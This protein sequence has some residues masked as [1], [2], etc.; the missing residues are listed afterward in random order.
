M[1]SMNIRRFWETLL[2][3]VFAALPLMLTIYIVIWLARTAEIFFGGVL[4]VFIPDRWYIPGSG[5]L[6]GLL[7]IF[8]LGLLTRV[9][10]FR[11]IA[12]YGERAINRVPVI[13]SIHNTLKDL[14][15]FFRKPKDEDF[16]DIVLVD[17][18]LG[19]TRGKIMGFVTDNVAPESA[20][21]EDGE[22]MLMIY[23]PM[24]YQIGGYTLTVPESAVTRLDMPM[25]DAMRHVLTAGMVKSDRNRDEAEREHQPQ[26]IG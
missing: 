14:T 21:A 5:M 12:N 8:V 22:D 20:A 10:L 17:V 18:D 13:N 9:W 24:S 6:T 23:F 7:L 25:E 26:I 15:D 4:K 16:S 2:A 11:E 1:T 19:G 3:G